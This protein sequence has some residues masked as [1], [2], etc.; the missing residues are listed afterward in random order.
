[1]NLVR[2]EPTTLSL[3]NS[4]DRLFDGIYDDQAVSV[5]PSMS[6]RPTTDGTWKS[7]CRA[8]PRRTS[9]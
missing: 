3:L 5:P 7:T 1:M 9:R 4:F 8:S 6:A 2:Y